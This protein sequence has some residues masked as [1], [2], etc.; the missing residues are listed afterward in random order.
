ML[1]SHAECR[2]RGCPRGG[3]SLKQLDERFERLE[4]RNEELRSENAMLR[5]QY[6]GVM[7]SPAQRSV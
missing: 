2:A 4:Q 5:S 1:Q 3:P 6:S 7:R